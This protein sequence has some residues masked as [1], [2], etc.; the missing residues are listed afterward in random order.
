MAHQTTFFTAAEAKE[1]SLQLGIWPWAFGNPVGYVPWLR[2]MQGDAGRTD[3]QRDQHI[4]GLWTCLT[5]THVWFGDTTNSQAK[6][7]RIYS[8]LVPTPQILQMDQ[9]AIVIPNCA[10]G[11]KHRSTYQSQWSPRFIRRSYIFTAIFA[12]RSPEYT[13][14]EWLGFVQVVDSF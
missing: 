2:G 5:H 3:P 6:S 11:L 8:K 12:A 13:A 1:A 7:G 4:H 9:N 14:W 10:P